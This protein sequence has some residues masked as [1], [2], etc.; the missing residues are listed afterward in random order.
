[1]KTVIVTG[2]AGGMGQVIVQQ[3]LEGKAENTIET[4]QYHLIAFTEWLD[5]E[6]L[7]LTTI[8]PTDFV[9]HSHSTA[10]PDSFLKL[11]RH[12]PQTSDT[13][14]CSSQYRCSVHS[15]LPARPFE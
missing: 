6:H 7:D 13:F 15:T 12:H 11:R 14:H 1:M 10:L 4:Y 8:H 5:K 9:R 2:A 3:L